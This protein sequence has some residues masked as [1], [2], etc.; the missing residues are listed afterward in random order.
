MRYEEKDF[1]CV[2]SVEQL[3]FGCS[4]HTTGAAMTKYKTKASIRNNEKKGKKRP[5]SVAWVTTVNSLNDYLN[6]QGIETTPFFSSFQKGL[7]TELGFANDVTKFQT[8]N[9]LIL[10]RFY[11]PD[12]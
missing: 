1:Y 4:F 8:T 5:N 12:V 10:L 6:D 9:L 7:T 11:F 2:V 3:G